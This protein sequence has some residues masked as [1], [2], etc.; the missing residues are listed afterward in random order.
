MKIVYVCAKRGLNCLCSHVSFSSK[1]F[2][3]IKKSVSICV[4]KGY[5]QRGFKQIL[6]GILTINFLIKLDEKRWC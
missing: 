1:L 5:Y 2:R 4:T 6:S 3:S